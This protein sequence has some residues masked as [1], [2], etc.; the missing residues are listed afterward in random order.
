MS[1][2]WALITATG[3]ASCNTL[4]ARSNRAELVRSPRARS[5]A[6]DYRHP[7]VLRLSFS[8]LMVTAA[9]GCVVS[10]WSTTAQANC[11]R[12]GRF[13]SCF[14][15]DPFWVSPGTGP[16]V[17][18]SP[19]ETTPPRHLVVGMA[20]RHATDPVTL[21]LPSPDPE[22]R[23]VGLVASVTVATLG[24]SY[25]FGSGSASFVSLPLTLD[26][27]G[28]GIETVTSQRGDELA[29]NPLRDPRV[30]FAQR[31]WSRSGRVSAALATRYTVALPLGDEESF[32]G[33]RGFV[34]APSFT[35]NLSHGVFFAGAE[36]GL[37]LRQP[38]ELAGSRIG[39]QLWVASGAG[40][41]L[42][43]DRRFAIA[44]E[45]FVA[46][47][48]APQRSRSSG[49]PDTLAPAEWLVSLQSSPLGSDGPTL[50][51]GAG[52]GLPTSTAADD[53]VVGVTSPRLRWIG[54]LRWPLALPGSRR[55]NG[56][57]PAEPPAR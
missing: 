25:G 12:S 34:G 8:H 15:A 42:T 21:E 40:I 11:S 24:L 51:I 18:V 6:V 36:L 38:V 23:E 7:S 17:T 31:L 39:S 48:L 27:Q 52:S 5:S 56:P 1:G 20:V 30:G 14:D 41:E 32:A 46:P 28:A 43:T 3:P 50:V 54:I 4:E 33:H 2:V 19:A 57:R 47:M 26:Q 55:A 29:P 35:M 22:G 49:N 53:P 44:A 37:R 10:A 9:L 45:F 13:S 16:F